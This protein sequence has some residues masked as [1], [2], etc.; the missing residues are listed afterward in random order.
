MAYVIMQDILKLIDLIL[1]DKTLTPKRKKEKSK[2][3]KKQGDR[4][5]KIDSTKVCC[6]AYVHCTS[7]FTIK[8]LIRRNTFYSMVLMYCRLEHVG[9]M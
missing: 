2:K 1:K 8:F 6:T 7:S 3:R 5:E 9:H 4:R